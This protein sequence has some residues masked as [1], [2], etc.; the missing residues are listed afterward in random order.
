MRLLKCNKSGLISLTDDL[1]DDE[2]PPYAILSHTWG[3][4]DEEVSLEDFS[5]NAGD[6]KA[7]YEKARFCGEQAVRDGLGYF[8]MDTC[9]IDQSSSTEVSTAVNSMFRWYHN[10]ERCYVYLSDVCGTALDTDDATCQQLWEAEFRESIWFTR[11]WTLQE[12]IAPKLVEFFSR[13][14]KKLG[15]K[16]SL[17]RQICEITGVPVSAL[18]GFP[19]SEFEI[20]ER[21]SWA[22]KRKTKRAEDVVYSLFGIF[23]VHLPVI[24]GEGLEH[25]TIRLKEEI[26]KRYSSKSFTIMVT[27]GAKKKS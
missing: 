16:K 26:H 6:S 11:G 12:L 10:A 9:C 27:A 1:A 2:I 4:P 7:G 18:R 22:A 14:G 15:D 17:E 23:G 25:A 19:L 5:K 13:D 21:F 3:K 8:W 20:H 24:Y